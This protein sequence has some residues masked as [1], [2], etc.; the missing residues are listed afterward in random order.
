MWRKL[1]HCIGLRPWDLVV[2][3]LPGIESRARRGESSGAVSWH[4]QTVHCGS[5]ISKLMSNK[6]ARWGWLKF[7]LTSK[8]TC[9][10]GT[11]KLVVVDNLQS[12]RDLGTS[13]NK[14]IGLT[15]YSEN[16]FK[17]VTLDRIECF[18]R[19]ERMWVKILVS[20]INLLYNVFYNVLSFLSLKELFSVVLRLIRK[21]LQT[22]CA[23]EN[24]GWIIKPGK[25][26][27]FKSERVYASCKLARSY[28]Y[29]LKQVKQA[30]F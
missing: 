24:A 26:E 6:Q 7:K 9:G 16:R 18:A 12:K 25:L 22:N 27:K 5:L 1:P 30:N 17:E 13:A 15:A 4:D 20:N 11:S 21:Q 28:Q 8:I 3:E 19:C 23:K 2:M 10:G 14:G 29:I